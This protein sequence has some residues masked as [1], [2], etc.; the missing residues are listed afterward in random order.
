MY[1]IVGLGNIGRQ[2]AETKHNIGFLLLDILAENL[3]CKFSSKAHAFVTSGA[4]G[5]C[6]SILIK[7]ST[8]MNNSGIAV[9]YWAKYYNINP[10]NIIVVYDDIDIP[11]EEIRVK[12]AGG[13][14][15]HNGI[16]SI[17]QHLK[18]KN[19]Y[20]IRV[21]VGRPHQEQDTISYVLS[22]FSKQQM[23]CIQGVLYEQVESKIS[24]IIT[25][26]DIN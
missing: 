16:K 17:D 3:V 7:P 20:R 21:G 25:N 18:D 4:I 2:Y 8:Y 23:S 13:S 12:K 14:A 19:Y 6:K 24:G 26:T 11:F 10:E 22:N 9:A 5:S 1:L 15:G